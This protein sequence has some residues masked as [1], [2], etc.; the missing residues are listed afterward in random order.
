MTELPPNKISKYQQMLIDE[1]ETETAMFMEQGQ[2]SLPI[3]KINHKEGTFQQDTETLDTLEG[4]ML[5][6]LT[7]RACWIKEHPIPFCSSYGGSWGSVIEIGEKSV[8]DEYVKNSGLGKAK[9]KE[10]MEKY[11][12]LQTEDHIVLCKDCPYNLYN[13]DPK[14][15]TAKACKE[16]RI[17]VLQTANHPLPFILALPSTSIR[18][19][20]N[21][22]THMENN[23]HP[24]IGSKVKL[25]LN[26]QQAVYTYS[27]VQFSFVSLLPD[28]KAFT[29]SKR[30]RDRIL[31]ILER[32]LSFR[33]IGVDEPVNGDQD[34][35]F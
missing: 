31:P 22:V 24:L 19:F 7:Q 28:I 13:S 18:Q 21:F 12:S 14:G 6:A 16:K 4:T 17:T 11:I 3:I 29:E 1:T 2:I 30:R 26:I 10:M 8:Y 32:Q 34:M 35:P 15:G 20:Q 23:L 5:C 27:V 33:E 25:S 9:A